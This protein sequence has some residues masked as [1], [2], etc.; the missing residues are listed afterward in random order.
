MDRKHLMVMLA[1][2]SIFGLIIWAVIHFSELNVDRL[3][4]TVHK[5]A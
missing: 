5:V 4:A 2:I 3:S 1:T